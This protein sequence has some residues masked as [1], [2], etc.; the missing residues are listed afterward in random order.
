MRKLGI[1]AS[2][3][4]IVGAITIAS[5]TS[6]SAAGDDK[7]AAVPCQRKDFKTKMV[8]EA[9]EKGGQAAAKDA[10]KAFNKDKKITSCNKCHD[11]L[12]PTYS[13]KADGLEQFKKLGGEMIDSAPAT[14]K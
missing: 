4:T 11:K 10:M 9:C 2:I 14:K 7:A 13:L 3:A 5:F 6:A 8:K 1:L 12:A